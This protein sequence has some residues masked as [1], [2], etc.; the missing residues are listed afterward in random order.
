MDIIVG[1]IIE[2][3]VADFA[4]DGE[5]VIKLDGY[6][7]FVPHA[8]KGEKI[9]A[10][11]TYVKKDCAFGEAV[12]I[13]TP[14]PLRVKPRCPYFGKCGGCDIQH[15]DTPLQLEI[16]RQ[17]VENALRKFAGLDLN[18]PLPTRL[19]D[20]EY[21]NKL[22]LPFAYNPRSKR[23]SLGF[24]EKRSHKVVP[25]KWCPLHGEWA[26]NV[27]AAVGEWANEF[28]IS[29]YDEN[30]HRG[31]LRHAVARMLDT[32]SLT[33]VINAV[34]L[35]KIEELAT[36][37][38]KYFSD[39]TLYV[40]ANMRRDNVILGDKVQLVYGRE[41]K[42]NLGKFKAV[43]SPK[44]FLQVNDKIRDA[45]YD[46]VAAAL[47]GFDGDIVEL[48]SGVG[49][50]TAQL[51]TRIEGA[52]IVSVEIEPS[53]SRDAS[54]LMSAL[55][56][57]NRVKCICDDAKNYLANADNG[58]GR[59]LILDPPRRGC[60]RAVLDSAT[61]FDRIIYVSCNPQTLARDLKILS[62]DYDVASVKPFDMFPQTSN[63]ECVAILKRK[64]KSRS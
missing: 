44:S 48:Y 51:A 5:G 8:L 24:Y 16:K 15:A 21:R 2:G 43:V 62:A 26:A 37:L 6:P 25:I 57:S 40:S 42:Q 27:I 63:V 60:D 4:S 17:S 38:Q 3:I 59:A 47:D 34:R 33:I 35:P 52:N 61:N 14:S 49:L 10:K 56:L 50:L 28:D 7:V 53:A 9:R 31:L 41:E 18:V 36:K 12:E 45:I 55:G 64:N 23:V 46:C 19:N 20:Y 39:F 58:E 1:D 22:S 32:L 54:E 13:V 29:V 11:I 30:T